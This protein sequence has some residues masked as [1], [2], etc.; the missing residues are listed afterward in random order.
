MNVLLTDDCVKTI[1]NTKAHFG[2]VLKNK[3][4]VHANF[5]RDKHHRYIE[6]FETV[7]VS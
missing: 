2:L 1:T 3:Y 5:Y 7:T 4:S 6:K